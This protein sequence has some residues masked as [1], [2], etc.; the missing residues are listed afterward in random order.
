MMMML[1]NQDKTSK[2]D[3]LGGC[4]FDLAEVP[5]RK[6][7]ES[8]LIPQWYRLESKTGKGRVQG[9]K[10]LGFFFFFLVFFSE[11]PGPFA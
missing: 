7:P 9:K 4:M 5:Q 3:F 2:D 1:V 11:V 8:P 6:P 10:T